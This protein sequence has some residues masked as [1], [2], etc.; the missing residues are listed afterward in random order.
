MK[1]GGLLHVAL[2]DRGSDLLARHRTP[3]ACL[4]HDGERHPFETVAIC[5]VGTRANYRG[6]STNECVGTAFRA[7][8]NPTLASLRSF[9]IASMTASINF[10]IFFRRYTIINEG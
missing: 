4:C 7:F 2:A 6:A 1:V 10:S 8:A 3:T 5:R 9:H